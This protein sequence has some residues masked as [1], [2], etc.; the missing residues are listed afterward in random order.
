MIII[1]FVVVQ[2]RKT[3]EREKEYAISLK[4]K[5]LDL[6]QAIIDTQELE[7]QKI[8]TNIHD[9][10][11]PLISTMKLHLSK[12]EKRLKK[13]T[14]KIEELV[15]ERK[16][17]DDIMESIRRT[18]QDLSPI[19]LLKFGLISAVKNFVNNLSGIQVTIVEKVDES[20]VINDR[21][22]I[23]IY[24]VIL[25]LFNNIVKHDK[26]SKIDVS[27]FASKEKIQFDILH[28]GLGISN[29]DFTKFID[30][31]KGLGLNSLKSRTTLLNAELNF[32]KGQCSKVIFIVPLVYEK[33]D[34]SRP[35]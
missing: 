32:Q 34:S 10:I 15:K 25:E 26:P 30:T 18:T 20:I 2:K 14:L 4:N 3:I 6:L 21:I 27:I 23:N 17:V 35:Y 16:Y 31:S 7:R 28:N 22:G 13:G 33:N 5:E 8:A 9:D 19:S 11:G 12:F 24:R 29:E 1:I